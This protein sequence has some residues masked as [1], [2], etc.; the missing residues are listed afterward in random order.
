MKKVKLMLAGLCVFMIGCTDSSV[1]S[2]VHS[3]AV[4]V[5][6]SSDVSVTASDTDAYININS[7]TLNENDVLISWE[8]VKNA[9]SY[10]VDFG[11]AS[12]QTNQ[13]NFDLPLDN[14]DWPNDMVG[15]ET[16]EIHVSA[17]S[18]DDTVFDPVTATIEVPRASLHFVFQDDKGNIVK[19]EDCPYTL[20]ASVQTMDLSKKSVTIGPQELAEEPEGWQFVSESDTLKTKLQ[21]GDNIITLTVNKAN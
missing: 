20:P 21:S 5:S 17:V 8:P 15:I 16:I 1:T 19:E 3:S 6:S 4:P 9:K 18:N 11:R 13:P 12:Y 14:H 7:T 2:H 10:M